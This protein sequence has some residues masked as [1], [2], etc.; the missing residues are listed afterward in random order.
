MIRNIFAFL[1]VFLM[2]LYANNVFAQDIKKFNVVISHSTYEPVETY[3]TTINNQSLEKDKTSSKKPI[4][5][6]IKITPKQEK[7][8]KDLLKKLDL[9]KNNQEYTNDSIID[10]SGISFEITIDDKKYEI[11][12][13]NYPLHQNFRNFINFINEITPNNKITY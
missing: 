1:F 8:L 5:T 4:I 12:Y 9:K 3:T 2:N 10:G 13:N 6:R 11:H 7:E